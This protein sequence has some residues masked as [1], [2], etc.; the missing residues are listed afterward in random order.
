MM[1][2]NSESSKDVVDVE[3]D[4]CWFW[5]LDDEFDVVTA[6]DGI[7]EVTPD[8]VVGTASQVSESS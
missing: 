8:E 7:V 2:P 4:R 1:L 5:R 3:A 6:A